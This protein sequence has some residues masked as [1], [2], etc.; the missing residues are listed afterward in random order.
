[1]KETDWTHGDLAEG[2]RC[3][4][5]QEFFEAHEHWEAVWLQLQD[6]EKSFLQGLIQVAAAFYHFQRGNLEGTTSLLL[7]ALRRLDRHSP[8]FA[9]ISLTPL[10]KEIRQWLKA[11]EAGEELSQLAFPQ[12]R[13]DAQSS[14]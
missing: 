7:G 14:T 4:H 11:M 1:V 12:I 6:P 10:C 9:G 5:A 8:S 13:L 3:Y 2:L